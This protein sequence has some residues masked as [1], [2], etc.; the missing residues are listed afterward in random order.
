MG[1]GSAEATFTA[2]LNQLKHLTIMF[3][4]TYPCAHYAIFWHVALLHVANAVLHDT[5]D[6]Q[7]RA[8]FNLC[9]DS[10]ADLFG[11]FRVAEGIVRGLLS[12]ALRQG[13][14]SGVEAQAYLSRVHANGVHHTSLENISASFVV[15]LKLAVMDHDAAQLDTLAKNFDDLALFDEFTFAAESLGTAGGGPSAT[16]EQF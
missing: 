3:R 14:V 1:D 13:I 16:D 2:S 9:V 5:R 12:V 15:D 8:Y 7:W 11:A 4:A 10:Y 6:S